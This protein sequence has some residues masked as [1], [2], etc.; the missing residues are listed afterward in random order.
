ML[1]AVRT[2][3]VGGVLSQVDAPAP[4]LSRGDRA[5]RGAL[6]AP[7]LG[8]PELGAALALQEPG[9]APARAVVLQVSHPPAVAADARPPW[10]TTH[11][12]MDSEHE[13]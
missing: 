3:R 11:G 2:A 1:L 9:A 5:Q 13:A 10:W 6:G 7:A 8:A 4:P 12:Q